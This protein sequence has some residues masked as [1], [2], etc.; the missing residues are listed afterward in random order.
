MDLIRASCLEFFEETKLASKIPSEPPLN[1][2]SLCK[3]F[4][5]S[6][7]TGVKYVEGFPTIEAISQIF[8]LCLEGRRQ[9]QFTPLSLRRWSE[10]KE[11]GGGGGGGSYEVELEE[12]SAGHVR[13]KAEYGVRV[14]TAFGERHT[15]ITKTSKII[16]TL[17]CNRDTL[18]NS[19]RVTKSKAYMR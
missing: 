10:R 14:R 11:E 8:F 15:A 17:T 2:T 3:D 1:K 5:S 13:P 16:L 19:S 12:V 4:D 6:E 7:S 9:S 18:E